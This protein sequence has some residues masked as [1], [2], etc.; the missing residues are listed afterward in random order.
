M[1]QKGAWEGQ[2]AITVDGIG[3]A[4]RFAKIHSY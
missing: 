4:F 3:H 2:A 1:E